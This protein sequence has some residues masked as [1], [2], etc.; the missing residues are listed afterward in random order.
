MKKDYSFCSLLPQIWAF[1]CVHK[2]VIFKL[3]FQIAL[4]LPT[5]E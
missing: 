4:C 5:A 2:K 3:K 1:N